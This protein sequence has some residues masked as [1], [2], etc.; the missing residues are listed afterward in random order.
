MKEIELTIDFENTHTKDDLHNKMSELF[1][2]PDFYGRN[3]DALI[4]CL[5][6]LRIPED[7]LTSINISQ[8]ECILLRMAHV[9]SLSAELAYDLFTVIQSVNQRG[10]YEDEK[11]TIRLVLC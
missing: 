4:D 10:Y 11:D 5:S 8:D 6:S 2:F 1:G 3:F 7:E 9:E